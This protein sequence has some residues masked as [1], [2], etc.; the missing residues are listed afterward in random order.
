MSRFVLDSNNLW[1]VGNSD[2]TISVLDGPDVADVN[3]KD[4]TGEVSQW[5]QMARIGTNSASTTH[6][7]LE[8][9]GVVLSGQKLEELRKNTYDDQVTVN[10]EGFMIQWLNPSGGNPYRRLNDLFDWS[11]HGV[12]VPTPV[13][14]EWDRYQLGTGE[15]MAEGSGLAN[16]A[17]VIEELE[18]EN[19]TLRDEKDL[20]IT[21][22]N[23]KLAEGKAGGGGG[24][25]KSAADKDKEMA[26]KDEQIRVLKEA[27]KLFL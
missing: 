4:V 8:V 10:R 5:Q 2:G 15:L 9:Y 16:L 22:L 23:K 13:A 1:L 26:V 27:L 12:E 3:P 11:K 19:Q 24:D 7:E 14:T 17:K 18:V 20:E 6:Q 21:E 25:D